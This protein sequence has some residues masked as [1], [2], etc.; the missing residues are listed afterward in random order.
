MFRL[1][2]QILRCLKYL[3]LGV[4]DAVLIPLLLVFLFSG[5]T[6]QNGPVYIPSDLPIGRTSWFGIKDNSYV[7]S[8]RTTAD[9]LRIGL[10]TRETYRKK[11]RK[12]TWPFDLQ[13]I[14]IKAYN[15]TFP[16]ANDPPRWHIKLSDNIVKLDYRL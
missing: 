15:P 7:Q 11:K 14:P 2:K 5:A 6:F 3:P 8:L 13:D 12:K 9:K 10:P 16:D 1:I 4:S